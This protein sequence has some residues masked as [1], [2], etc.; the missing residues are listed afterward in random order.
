MNN[1][2]NLSLLS[3]WTVSSQQAPLPVPVRTI[4]TQD[5]ESLSAHGSVSAKQEPL[6]GKAAVWRHRTVPPN[7]GLVNPE[8]FTETSRSPG[9]LK[10]YCPTFNGVP[11]LQQSV[12]VKKTQPS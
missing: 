10:Q 9:A 6:P 8:Y 4:T 11:F 1:T 5:Q 2:K 12:P 7:P 3:L